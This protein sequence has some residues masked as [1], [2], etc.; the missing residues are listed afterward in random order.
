MARKIQNMGRLFAETCRFEAEV[1]PFSGHYTPQEISRY[2]AQARL[3]FLRLSLRFY[4]VNVHLLEGEK[5]RVM[6]TAR[7]TGIMKTEGALEET[8]EVEFLLEKRENEWLFT[9]CEVVEVLEQ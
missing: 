5:A 6:A 9:H 4:D 8:H 2:A 7:A 3:Q 1:I